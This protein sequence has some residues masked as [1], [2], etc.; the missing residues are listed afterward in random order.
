VGFRVLLNSFSNSK[1]KKEK[2]KC[3][4]GCRSGRDGLDMF[5]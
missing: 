4:E 2:E 3:K 1:Q 5:S